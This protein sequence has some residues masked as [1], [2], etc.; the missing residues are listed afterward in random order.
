LTKQAS[1]TDFG[2]FLRLMVQY[3]SRY[4]I[5]VALAVVCMIL[6]A[7]TTGATAWLLKYIVQGLTDRDVTMLGL[8][9]GAAIGLQ[10][11][12]AVAMYA[13]T[14][15]ISAVSQRV[16][17]DLQLDVIRGY[18]HSD[19]ERI[20]ST[21]SG[22]LITQALSNTSVLAGGWTQLMLSVG[23]DAL[24]VI[25]LVAVMFLQDWVLSLLA[26]AILPILIVN[27]MRQGKV[28][29]KST[30]QTMQESGALTALLSDNLDGFRVVKA[31]G[32]EEAE[33][34]RTR[35][36]IDRRI[37]F[38]LKGIRAT[39][40]NIPLSEAASGFAIAAI[41]GYAFLRPGFTIAEFTAF[42]SATLLAY[43]PIRA[44]TSAYTNIGVSMAAAQSV[45]EALDTKPSI[46]DAPHAR[47][48]EI[49]AGA[50]RL[51]D[52]SFG[53][54]SDK[55]VLRN[56]TLAIPAGKKTALVGPSGAGK[57][58]LLNL[59]LRFY[60]V[61]SGAVLIDGQ[62]VRAVTQ[63]SLRRSVALVTQEP[64]LFDDTVSA[65][66]AYGAPS[67]PQAA[68]E[69]AAKAAAAHDFILALKD[70]YAHKVG[71]NGRWLSGGQRQRVAIARALLKDAPILLLD[72]AT[73]SL[74]TESEA[75][76]QA[77][78][79]ALMSGRTSVVIA[80][81]L[82]TILDADQIVVM[83]GGRVIDTGAHNELLQRCPLYQRLYN[84]QSFAA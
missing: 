55:S 56:V 28:A 47:P 12:K 20:S 41:I 50:I 49:P 46:K 66:I 26:L 23:R 19:L 9:A 39:A 65:N 83:D 82:S 79:R 44:L 21:H 78:L 60:D 71:E 40:A 76:V 3:F 31:H 68:I 58:T 30:T 15:F 24:S 16:V 7:A 38:A 6:V 42:I 80:H 72:E 45:F 8:L 75:Q 4:R 29:R 25:A 34:Q 69:R 48:L 10:L 1:Q 73:A 35:A 36:R 81:R 59:I 84:G 64:F 11:V 22:V 52:V 5:R 61:S 14:Y 18:Y 37:A 57:S 62:D 67:A 53:Y 13:Q 33:V 54:D 17:G 77:G 43:Q 70:G 63:A 74:D 51:E 2:I 27:M 32:T